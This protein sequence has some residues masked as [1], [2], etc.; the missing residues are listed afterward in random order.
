MQNDPT[1]ADVPRRLAEVLLSLGRADEARALFEQALTHMPDVAALH[2]GLAD[3]LHML[4]QLPQAVAAYRQ[5][6]DLE[7]GMVRAWW[8][9]GCA[10]SAQREHACAVA[11]LQRVVQLAPDHG[12]AYHN[13]GKHLF[14]LGQVDAA[15]DAFH[16]AAARLQ[17]PELPLGMIAMVIPGSPRAN[18]QTILEARRTWAMRYADQA[19]LRTAA[20]RSGALP[21]RPLRVG[22]VSAF[23]QDPNWM[24]PVW[25]LINHHDLERFEIHL[26]SDAPANAIE[27]GSIKD[28]LN[29]HEVTPLTNRELAEVIDRQ[30]IDILVDLN[31]YC[32]ISRLP[33]FALRPAPIVITWFGLYATSGMDCF[34]CLIGDPHVFAAGDEPY[35]SEKVVCVP[36][37]W[38]TS[39]VTYPVPDVAPAPCLQR[40]VITFGC[41]APQYKITA[42]VAETFARI[43]HGS[44]GSRLILKNRALASA[45]NRRWVQDLFGRFGVAP[46]R[47]ELNGPAR[48]FEF[49][50]K[51]GEI[52]I[53]LDT[54]PYNGGTTTMEALWQG[55]PVLTF[56]GDRWA[57]RISASLLRNAWLPEFV[58]ADHEGFV[59]RAIELAG[60]L[61]IRLPELMNCGAACANI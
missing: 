4:G 42:E 51:Y 54:F 18:Q 22:Y 61:P 44:P 57:G 39:E 3:A 50:K 27:H 11:S 31:G 36:G 41:L 15:L 23:F 43:L 5:A 21:G 25:G 33:L 52:D 10:E 13:L 59:A 14:E 55:V 47:I 49:L 28:S 7:P 12:Q 40:G 2:C 17:D 58:A 24:K 8:G 26:F 48:H 6:L 16:Q 56:Y 53:A 34:D 20:K 1:L 38:L 60:R 9:R 35:Y 45:D 30:A 32:R 46:E 29:Y 37:C 19:V